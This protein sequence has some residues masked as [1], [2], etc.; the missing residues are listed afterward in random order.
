MVR[1]LTPNRISAK[2][3]KLGNVKQFI[4]LTEQ[5][6]K[7]TNRCPFFTLYEYNNRFYSKVKFKQFSDLLKNDEFSIKV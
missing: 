5:Y 6:S 3:V 7:H 2:I 4:L 1:G